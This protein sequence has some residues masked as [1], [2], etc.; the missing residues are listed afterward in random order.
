VTLVRITD[1]QQKDTR[2]VLVESPAKG[3]P[4][5]LLVK[6]LDSFREAGTMTCSTFQP[7]PRRRAMPL[8]RSA[9]AGAAGV[10]Q[11]R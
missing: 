4:P 1:V 8:R 7:Y 11:G 6:L 2:T 9:S 3:G 10:D 5:D